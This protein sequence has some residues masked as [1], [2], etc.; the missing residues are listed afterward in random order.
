MIIP[1][2]VSQCEIQIS[3]ICIE[4]PFD[5]FEWQPWASTETI[6]QHLQA[7]G[8]GREVLL[9]V[10]SRR[11]VEDSHQ[12]KLPFQKT[13]G[14]GQLWCC[15]SPFYNVFRCESSSLDCESSATSKEWLNGSSQ[16]WIN[17]AHKM[18]YNY[19]KQSCSGNGGISGRLGRQRRWGVNPLKPQQVISSPLQQQTPGS[20]GNNLLFQ[21]LFY[22]LRCG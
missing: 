8:G 21:T 22:L 18:A 1:T 10:T 17:G 19:V 15:V 5:F 7:G 9:E 3:L 2:V 20:R 12:N 4:P 14:L 13:Q 11:K 16:D 6:I